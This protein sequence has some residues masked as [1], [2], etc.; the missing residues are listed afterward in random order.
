VK[1]SHPGDAPPPT[2]LS[3]LAS[4]S[5]G[6]LT[7]ATSLTEVVFRGFDRQAAKEMTIKILRQGVGLEGEVEFENEGHL[8]Q[9]RARASHVVTMV[10]VGRGEVEINLAPSRT[11]PVGATVRIP[12]RFLA[13]ELADAPAGLEGIVIR[14]TG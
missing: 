9:L 4:A 5:K 11:M 1:G 7:F 6:A 10:S 8:L 3:T 12:V 14:R 2:C 13:L